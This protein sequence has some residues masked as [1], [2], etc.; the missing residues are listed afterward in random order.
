MYADSVWAP[1]SGCPC[2]NHHLPSCTFTIEPSLSDDP[3][4]M[5]LTRSNNSPSQYEE[6][7]L[8]TMIS[9]YDEQIKG[10]ELEKSNLEAFSLSLNAQIVAVSQKIEALGEEHARVTEAVRER[11]DLLSP[12]RRLPPEVLNHIFLNTID[13][14]VPRTPIVHNAVKEEAIEISP[15]WEF[16]ATESSLWSITG[17]S[18]KWRSVSLSSPRLW[19]YVNIMITDSNF[20]DYSYIRQLGLQLDRSAKYPLSMLICHIVEESTAEYL[21]PQ[22]VAIL[23]SF[24]TCI[25]ELHLFLPWTLFCQMAP[26]HLSLPSL[27]NLII[28]C[29][30]GIYPVESLN[31]R[32]LSFA[33]RLQS[34]EVVDLVDPQER[35]ELPWRQLK[36][37]RSDHTYQP[38]YPFRHIG[39]R[40]HHH[41]DVLRKLQQVEECVLRFGDSS[42]EDE[43]GNE[44][45]PLICPQLHMLDISSWNIDYAEQD[46]VF[47][48][49]ANRLV[50]PGL[51]V[52]KV[53][54]SQRDNYETPDVFTSICHLLQRSQSPITVLHFDH[55]RIL[56]KDLLQLF[57]SAPTLE[58][59]RL[60]RLGTGVFTQKVMEKLTLDRDSSGDLVLPHLRT[61]Y[62]PSEA[63]K[64]PDLV[65]MVRSR[66]I[67]DYSGRFNRLQTL[68]L[69]GNFPDS[70]PDLD[71]IISDL[72]QYYAEGFSFG[73]CHNNA[74]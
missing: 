11:R 26:L 12:V 40:A 74:R 29:T 36:T 22:L 23:F 47:Q 71:T 62:M 57:R 42:E 55:G 10:I 72:K 37:Y 30:D 48:Q 32:L 24:S 17:V 56:T 34:L 31:L 13:F 14:P 3:E 9:A 73:I 8:S 46:S 54:C 7:V 70:C 63:V 67:S 25:R 20:A 5:H 58:D 15:N 27:K 60:T 68:R 49:V 18:T 4:W 19:S 50:L 59:L 61:L 39:P 52:L 33:P 69:C 43:F 1:C 44:E 21:P 28:L 66:R 41:L 38:V 53:A 35:F 45:Y 65:R 51:S 64:I 6:M 2:P 16:N